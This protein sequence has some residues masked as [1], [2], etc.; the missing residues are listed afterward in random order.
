LGEKI[1][2]HDV[3]CWLVNTGWTGGAYGTGHRMPIGHTRALLSAALD[4]ALAEV[5]VRA[6]QSFNL[7]VPEACEGVPA[8]V[9]TPR[10]TWSDKA[11]YDGAASDLIGRFAANF[12]QFEG[13]VGDEVKEAAPRAA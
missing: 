9:L 3:T 7:Q 11:A 5:P 4:G 10:E 12:E 6:D 2:R 13:G 8:E 1:A